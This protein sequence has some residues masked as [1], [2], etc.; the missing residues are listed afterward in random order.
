MGWFKSQMWKVLDW[1]DNSKDTIV[2]RFPMDDKEIMSGSQLT[3]RESQE[4]VFVHLGQYADLFKAGKY[5]LTTAN[6]PILSGLGSIFYQGESRFKAELYFINTKQFLD[7]NWGTMQPIALRD[8]DF[9]MIRIKA[10]GNYS[11][12]IE[13]SVLFMREVFGTNGLYK[14]GDVANYLQ[15]T[16]LAVMTDVIGESKISALD[17]AGNQLEFAEMVRSKAMERFSQLGILLTDYSIM[18]INFPEA[19]EKALDERTALGIFGDKMGTYTQKKA[20]DA[21]EGFSNNSGAGA[22]FMGIGVAQQ[23]GGAM[24]GMF[25]NVQD[26][27]RQAPQ[28]QTQAPAGGKFCPECGTPNDGAKFCPNCGAKQAA[29]N[30][31]SKCGAELKAGAKFCPEC[32]NKV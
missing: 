11:F 20:A 9:G 10:F 3:V 5:K 19:V 18:N 21:L 25:N 28:Q 31:C 32:G 29:S 22:Q 24:S 27:P 14:V 4:A 1:E 16:L 6:L 15:K 7:N 8:A 13:D 12:K 26:T 17:M 2:Y 23:M 30:N